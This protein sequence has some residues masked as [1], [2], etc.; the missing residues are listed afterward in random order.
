[1]GGA[2][3]ENARMS[4]LDDTDT[5]LKKLETFGKRATEHLFVEQ[6]SVVVTRNE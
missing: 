5:M 2:S 1:M 6:A 4:R 3:F